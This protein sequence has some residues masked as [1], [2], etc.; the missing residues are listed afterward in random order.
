MFRTWLAEGAAPLLTMGVPAL[1]AA[2]AA[3]TLMLCIRLTLR[4]TRVR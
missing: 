1:L 2:L 4:L 3:A